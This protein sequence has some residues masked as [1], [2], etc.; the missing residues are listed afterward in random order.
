[1]SHRSESFTCVKEPQREAAENDDSSVC[2]SEGGQ[3]NSLVNWDLVE[4]GEEN[5]FTGSLDISDNSMEIS[6]RNMDKRSFGC[7]K[8]SSWIGKTAS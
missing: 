7:R 6:M 5:S 3:E 1:M 2:Q 8:W 4:G